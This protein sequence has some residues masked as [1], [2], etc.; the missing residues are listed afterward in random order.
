MTTASRRLSIPRQVVAPFYALWA[1]IRAMRPKTVGLSFA[2]LALALTV[3]ATVAALIDA[4]GGG[5]R[6]A[7]EAFLFP[8]ELRP[9]AELALDVVFRSQSQ[10]LVAN[11]TA[12]VGLFVVS[13]LLFFVKEKLSQSVESDLAKH[14]GDLQPPRED[15]PIW[16]EAIEEIGLLVIYIALAVVVFAVGQSTDPTR[17]TVAV[18][19]SYAVLFW[20]W[21]V[22]FI[23]P[24]LFRRRISYRGV[25]RVIRRNPLMSI[26]FGAATSLIIVGV[27]AL[28]DA[29]KT[30][31]INAMVINVATQGL[32]I[33]G[34]TWVGTALTVRALAFES[35]ADLRR[36][37]PPLLRAATVAVVASVLVFGGLAMT[38]MARALANKA[39]ILKCAYRIIPG[40][41]DIKLPD[42]DPIGWLAGKPVVVGMSF[43]LQVINDSSLPVALEATRLE[44][45]DGDE[46]IATTTVDPFNVPKAATITHTMNLI[47]GIRPTAFVHGA[48][49]N[50]A[51]WTIA[52]WVKLDSGLDFPIP[53]KVP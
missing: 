17:R 29:L 6:S 10:A 39:Q 21:A 3:L 19:L 7:F 40:S 4:L 22:D 23:A 47:L 35:V 37:Q 44:V 38:D 42:V 53:L 24:A 8:D 43:Q 51:A 25:F 50:P 34:A 52:L 48:S 14:R 5:L 12:T 30:P 1:V 13:L 28:T 46:V 26:I 45:T 20:T 2:Y 27:N 18:V 9:F 16:R 11:L 49:L 15:L 33:V 41:V 36:P 31:P 32:V